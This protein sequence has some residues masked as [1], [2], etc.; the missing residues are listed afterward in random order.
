M[1]LM[2]RESFEVYYF[3]NGRWSVHASY[4]PGQRELAIEEAKNVEAQMGYP[5]RVVRETFYPETNTTEEVVSWQGSRAKKVADADHMFGHGGQQKAPASAKSGAKPQPRRQPVAEPRPQSPTQQRTAP[6]SRPAPK[7]APPPKPKKRKKKRGAFMRLLGSVMISLGIA[8][9]GA[10]AVALLFGQLVRSGVAQA[11]SGP[12]ALFGS[13]IL[14]FFLSLLINLHREFNILAMLK[15][16]PSQRRAKVV[17]AP[18]QVQKAKPAQ[19]VEFVHEVHAEEAEQLVPDTLEETPPETEPETPPADDMG[20]SEAV[21]T[22]APTE[23]QPAAATQVPEPIPAQQPAA[24]Q[25]AAPQPAAAPKTP[26]GDAEARQGFLDFITDATASLQSRNVE[27]NAFSRFGFNLYLAGACAAI[28]QAKKIPRELQLGV[29]RQGLQVAG[30]PPDRADAICVELPSYGKNPRYQGMVQAGAKSM[31]KYLGG[32][33]DAVAELAALLADWNLPDKRP[34]VPSVITF[35][36]TDIVGSTAMTQ[37]LGNAGA[38]KAVRAHNNAVRNAIKAFGGREVKHTGD[39]IMA[40]FPDPSAAVAGSIQAQKEVLAH[41]AAHPDLEVHVRIGVNAGEAVEEE[42]DFFGAAVQMTAR[43]CDKASKDNVW[44][45]QTVVDACGK[46][47]GF[48]PR[49]RFEMKGIQQ[50]RPL[51]EVGFTDA[52]KNELAD[53]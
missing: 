17:S 10:A 35:V 8:V 27:L 12:T 42:N 13:F 50:A 16:Q 26:T 28:G 43:I 15:G 5:A 41:N 52:H 14:L 6:T 19:D 38:Q 39:G 4:E 7:G 29:L 30:T 22:E 3:Q 1:P 36:F 2:A 24:Q 11:S 23:E 53:L 21:Q 31:S 34:A 51:Y 44:V 48:I 47:F 45:S 20:F 46:K 25:T 33:R 49:G 40:T 37:R 32:S 9:V 18:V